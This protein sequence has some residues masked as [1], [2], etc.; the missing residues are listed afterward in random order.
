[1]SPADGPRWRPL[2]LGLGLGLTCGLAAIGLPS[3]TGSTAWFSARPASAPAL[4][5]PPGRLSR[6]ALAVPPHPSR[7]YGDSARVAEPPQRLDLSH[8]PQRPDQ[9]QG[10]LLP[11]ILA[12]LWWL[13]S[14]GASAMPGDAP[15]TLGAAEVATAFFAG[16]IAAS[17]SHALAVPLD[18]VKTRKQLPEYNG[19]ST[20]AVATRTITAEPEALLNGLGATFWGYFAQGGVKF[21]LFLVLKAELAALEAVGLPRPLLLMLAGLGADVV[22]TAVLCAFEAVRINQVAR[23]GGAFWAVGRDL[24]QKQLLFTGLAPLLLKQS[25]YTTAQ[26]PTYDLATEAFLAVHGGVRFTD[27]VASALLAAVLASLASQPGDTVLSRMARDCGTSVPPSQRPRV[28]DVLRELGPAGAFTGWDA[29]LAQMLVIV[30]VQLLAYD[31]ISDVVNAA[32]Q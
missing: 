2:A 4:T 3:G 19:V 21:G 22:A 25:A 9:A 5:R 24:W 27:R 16:G 11:A 10:Y 15:Q 31:A 32:L 23:R 26:L 14:D 12:T 1:M 30:T 18:V 28:V 20:W 7:T 13:Q 29:R 6:P 17:L 8:R